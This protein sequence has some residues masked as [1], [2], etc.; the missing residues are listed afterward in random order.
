MKCII[1]LIFII[2]ATLLF[3]LLATE[4]L[5]MLRQ[6]D[7]DLAEQSYKQLQKTREI[8]NSNVE[9]MLDIIAKM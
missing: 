1:K 7:M 2:I 9:N 8:K 5:I 6:T 4:G 3:Q